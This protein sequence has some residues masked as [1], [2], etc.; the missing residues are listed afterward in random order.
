MP[1]DSPRGMAVSADARRFRRGYLR[2]IPRPPRSLLP[3]SGIYHVTARG[4]ARC[5]I[6][7][8]DADRRLFVERLRRLAG[9][10][11]IECHVPVAADLCATPDEWP[12]TG[13]I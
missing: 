12:W 4:V 9:E 8:D 1:R 11:E 5:A 7:H 13:S 6:F 2:S 10:L 3:S